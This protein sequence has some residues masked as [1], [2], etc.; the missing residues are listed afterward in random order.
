MICGTM[1]M[2]VKRKRLGVS[3]G[4]AERLYSFRGGGAHR[5]GYLEHFVIENIYP[6]KMLWRCEAKRNNAREVPVAGL[7]PASSGN[8]KRKM[9]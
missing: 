1:W 4:V 7:C 2:D 5:G 9:L 6:E 8:L 3:T